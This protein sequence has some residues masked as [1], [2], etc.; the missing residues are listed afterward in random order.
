MVSQLLGGPFTFLGQYEEQGLVVMVRRD[1][2]AEQAGEGVGGEEGGLVRNGHKLQP[3]LHE[4]V[5]FGDILLMRV[6]D[7]EEE[8]EAVAAAATVADCGE[9]TKETK[10]TEEGGT[11][12]EENGAS[13]TTQQQPQDDTTTDGGEEEEAS[14]NTPTPTPAKVLTNDEFFLD[15]TK[16]EYLTFAARTDILPPPPKDDGETEETAEHNDGSDE[17][18]DENDELAEDQDQDAEYDIEDEDSNSD[19]DGDDCQIGMMNLIL[20]QILK[21]FQE[22]NGRGPDTHEL[23]TMRAALAEKLGI[24]GLPPIEGD[25]DGDSGVEDVCSGEEDGDDGAADG[26]DEED[27][28]ATTGTLRGKR[29]SGAEEEEEEEE[30][31][32][33]KRVKFSNKDQIKIIENNEDSIEDTD[34]VDAT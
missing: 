2:A 9:S 18:S 12:T 25:G 32:D 17:S 19:D 27:A 24:V 15:Y 30:T 20:G 8:E 4:E 22:A 6:A 16:D 23:L 28:A 3:P 31:S 1:Q 14:N 26:E 5:V 21:R 29:K 13:P 34:T 11:E 7:A 33:K 10:G